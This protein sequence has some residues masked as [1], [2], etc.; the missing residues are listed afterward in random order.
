MMQQFGDCFITYDQDVDSLV[1]DWGTIHMVCEERVTGAKSISF[2][3]VQLQP[4]KGH[5][6]HNH[7]DADEIIFV[8][9]GEGDQ[10]LDD[11]EP[12][13]VKPGACIWIPK[14]IYH[15]TVN[16]GDGVLFLV[17]AYVPAG[18]EA[19][20]R[21]DPAVTIIPAGQSA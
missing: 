4:G 12:V 19:A 3:T 10:M 16:R 11:H 6:R 18:S 13:R 20:L 14:G 2:G 8:V 5:T 1:F 7:P 17:V 15:S 21:Q 9:S